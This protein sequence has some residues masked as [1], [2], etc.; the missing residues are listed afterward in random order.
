MGGP[1]WSQCL[2]RAPV[3]GS[4]YPAGPGARLNQLEDSPGTTVLNKKM[5]GK[6]NHQAL[7]GS[8]VSFSCRGWWQGQTVPGST[9]TKP[10]DFTQCCRNKPIHAPRRCFIL[11]SVRSNQVRQSS[12]KLQAGLIGAGCMFYL[13]SAS[14]IPRRN[15][16]TQ[17][18]RMM[19][20]RHEA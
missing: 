4:R 2:I 13:A 11:S 1:Q 10:I 3:S 12:P 19:Q 20:L 5:R 18:P 14:P 6:L 8:P 15:I 17:S 16:T 9:T 7:P